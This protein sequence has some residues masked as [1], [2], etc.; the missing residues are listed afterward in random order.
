MCVFMK[1]EEYFYKG[2]LKQNSRTPLPQSRAA[3]SF[4]FRAVWNIVY[5]FNSATEPFCTTIISTEPLLKFLFMML[6]V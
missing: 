6:Q 5:L 1:S 4:N 3:N 2:E